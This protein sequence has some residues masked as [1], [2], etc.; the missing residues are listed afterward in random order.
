MATGVIRP[1]TPPNP[2]GACGFAK[3]I[4]LKNGRVLH[5]ETYGLRAFPLRGSKKK[6]RKQ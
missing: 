5:A 2:E 3:T 4:T 1:P 6:G